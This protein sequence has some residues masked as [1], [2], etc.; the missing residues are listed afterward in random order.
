MTEH[1]SLLEATE[2]KRPSQ[3]QV[4]HFCHSPSS[5]STALSCPSSAEPGRIAMLPEG[6][7]H[8]THPPQVVAPQARPKWTCR[9]AYLLAATGRLQRL[10][11]WRTCCGT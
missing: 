4:A 11:R 2:G 5:W 1:A 7:T 9:T 3:E 10:P 6:L 8:Q